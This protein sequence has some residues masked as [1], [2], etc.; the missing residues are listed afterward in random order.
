MA[1][2]PPFVSGRQHFVVYPCRIADTEHCY[3]PVYQFLTNPIDSGITLRADKHLRFP[4]QR[5]VNGFDKRS[6]LPGS[7]RTVY[8]GD[9]TRAEHLVDGC[10][11]RIVQPREAYRI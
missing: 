5:F 9:V 8:D 7:R 6:R 11:L 4:V 10:F 1:L 3:S 2:K